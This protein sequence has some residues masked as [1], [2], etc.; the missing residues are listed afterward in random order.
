MYKIGA[1]EMR[2]DSIYKISTN[3]WRGKTDGW[4][5]NWFKQRRKSGNLSFCRERC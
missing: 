2:D 4:I 5:D 3:F 1:K